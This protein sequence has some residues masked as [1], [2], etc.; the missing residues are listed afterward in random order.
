[1]QGWQLLLV[2]GDDKLPQA[3]VGHLVL[4]CP[5]VEEAVALDAQ[6]GLQPSGRVIYTSVYDPRVVGAILHAKG[7]MAL[8][9]GYR[10]ARSQLGSYR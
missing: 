3:A 9:D 5:L 10:E 1:V 6:D 2:P 7:V 8:Q 4:V